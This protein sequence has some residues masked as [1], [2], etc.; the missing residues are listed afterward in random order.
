MKKY[1]FA[2]KVA[3]LGLMMSV[4][5]YALADVNCVR[6]QNGDCLTIE[7]IGSGG[8]GNI[9]WGGGNAGCQASCAG[10]GDTSSSVGA[11]LPKGPDGQVDWGKVFKTVKAFCKKGGESCEAWGVRMDTGVCARSAPLFVSICII[12]VQE[13]VTTDLAPV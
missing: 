4:S 8:G 3:L 5:G 6:D 10:G 12:A 9:D 7:V 1:L 13:E 2:V 11:T